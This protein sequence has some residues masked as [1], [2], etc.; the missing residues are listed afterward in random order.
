VLAFSHHL[1]FLLYH[2]E[3]ITCGSNSAIISNKVR[4]F[5]KLAP[6]NNK[7][8]YGYSPSQTYVTSTNAELS[9]KFNK[10]GIN[11]ANFIAGYLT[12]A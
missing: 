1:Y 5:I 8:H 6:K 9:T 2:L 3:V 7:K 12:T 4:K 10:A 11:E